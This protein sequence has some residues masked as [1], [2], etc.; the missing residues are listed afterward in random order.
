MINQQNIDLKIDKWWVYK[1]A[2]G[3]FT[4]LFIL[5][6]QHTPF[7][8]PLIL[9]FSQI[10]LLYF[11]LAITGHMLND[12]FDMEYDA[13]AQKRNMFGT[14]KKLWHLLPL[15]VLPLL[16]LGCVLVMDGFNFLFYLD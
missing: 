2:G 11:L 8:W 9:G 3:I 7:S 15:V 13:I 12:Y 6:Y 4:W 10:L 14:T 5:L 16:A 1:I